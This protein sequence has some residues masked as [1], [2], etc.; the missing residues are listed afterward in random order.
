VKNFRQFLKEA[1]MTHDEARRILGLGPNFTAA[2]LKVA[3]RKASVE[4]HPDR[5][6]DLRKMQDINAANDVLSPS[7]VGAQK[8]ADNMAAWKE[9]E[10]ATDEK[11]K[12]YAQIAIDAFTEHFNAQAFAQHF[13]KVF[14]QKFTHKVVKD[15]THQGTSY[16]YKVSYVDREDEWVNADRS[17][18]MFADFTINFNDLLHKP[19]LSQADAET[20][21]NVSIRSAILVDRKKVKLSQSNYKFR[22]SYKAL[23]DPEVVF[24]AKKMKVQT[25]KAATRAMSKRDVILTFAN[26]LEARGDDEWMYVP[27]GEYKVALNRHVIMRTAGWMINGVYPKKGGSRLAQAVGYASWLE[28]ETDMNALWDGLKSLQRAGAHYTPEDIAKFLSG[29]QDKQKHARETRK[30]A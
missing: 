25:S 2:D 15:P 29:M 3:Y 19:V 21:L 18:V 10:A 1:K 26:E 22:E 8:G 23:S 12:V 30:T 28:D 4:N 5:G 9:R 13:E 7:A 11:R 16:G 6:G 14:G 17:I 20:N 27:V 24:P